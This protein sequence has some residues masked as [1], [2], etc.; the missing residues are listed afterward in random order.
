MPNTCSKSASARYS[1]RRVGSMPSSSRSVTSSSYPTVSTPGLSLNVPILSSCSALVVLALSCTVT[2]SGGPAGDAARWPPTLAAGARRADVPPTG[3]VRSFMAAACP[4]LGDVVFR[5]DILRISSRALTGA[6]A[7]TSTM[8]PSLP[9][10]AEASGVVASAASAAGSG[11]FG[12]AAA[13]AGVLGSAAAA[14]TGVGVLDSAAGSS[15]APGA[16]CAAA[17]GAASTAGC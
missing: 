5:D 17:P 2:T 6:S 14:A 3:E 9:L 4:I 10:I 13:G 7:S 16:G 1:S 8:M 11:A 15:V 12:T